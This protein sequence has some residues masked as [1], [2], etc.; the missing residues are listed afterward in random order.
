[1]TVSS[2]YSAPPPTP[3]SVRSPHRS[4]TVH[5]T[6]KDFGWYG[7]ATCRQ[8]EARRKSA[9]RVQ[10]W[11]AAHPEKARQ[12]TREAVRRHREKP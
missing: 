12:Q 1:M 6:P 2:S 5:E 10:R 11:R 3:S 4:C 8:E 9:A 7:C